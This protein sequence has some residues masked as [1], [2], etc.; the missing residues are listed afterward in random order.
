MNLTPY[1]HFDMNEWFVTIAIICTYTISYFLPR[2]LKAESTFLLF[3]WGFSVAKFWD[4]TLGG[5]VFDFYDVN[6]SPYYDVFDFVSYF[7]YSPFSYFFIYFY[8]V[9]G[10]YAKAK[11]VVVYIVV[12][13]VIAIGVEWISVLFKMITYKNGYSLPFSI[14]IYLITFSITILFYRRINLDSVR[15][16]SKK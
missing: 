13:S 10:I 1:E 9:F 3:L 8:E 11:S 7:L 4:F 16:I 5:G 6:D 12:W 2:K 15:Q 14:P